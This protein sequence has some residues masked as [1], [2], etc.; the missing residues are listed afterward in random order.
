MLKAETSRTSRTRAGVAITGFALPVM[1]GLSLTFVGPAAA[2]M[3]NKQSSTAAQAQSAP[4]NVMSFRGSTT[5][6]IG[7][8]R[9]RPALVGSA[10]VRSGAAPGSA[11]GVTADRWSGPAPAGL[12]EDRVPHNLTASRW[13]GPAPDVM[14]RPTATAN[15]A[16]LRPVEIA[17]VKAKATMAAA[18][19]PAAARAPA[20]GATRTAMLTPSSTMAADRSAATELLKSKA[21][22]TALRKARHDA[23]AH[24]R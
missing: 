14:A 13:S 12:T 5:P 21:A 18:V 16:L 2:D 15:E 10:A 9:I 3:T 19:A 1:V 7:K 4:S 11:A 24:Q 20:S 8:S 6:P 23:A 22:V 17:A